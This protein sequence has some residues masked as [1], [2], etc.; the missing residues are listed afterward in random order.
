MARAI[1][2]ALEN[3]SSRLRRSALSTTAS[4]SGGTLGF[5]S[6]G[7]AASVSSAAMISASWSSPWNSRI[8][9]RHSWNTTPSE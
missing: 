8:P 4:I 7:G 2:S 5:C 9:V 1:S 3:R 6:D